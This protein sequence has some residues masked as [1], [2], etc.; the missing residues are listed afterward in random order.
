MPTTDSTPTPTAISSFEDF[1]D[2]DF[3]EDA[4]LLIMI[5]Q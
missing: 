4:P 3:D 5:L 2:V 1:G